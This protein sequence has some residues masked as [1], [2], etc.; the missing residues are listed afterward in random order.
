MKKQLKAE[1]NCNFLESE[2]VTK[3]SFRR[4][5]RLIDYI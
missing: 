1:L 2:N 4:E 5:L 3:R